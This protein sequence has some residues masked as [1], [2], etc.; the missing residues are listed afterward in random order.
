MRRGQATYRLAFQR[1]ETALRFATADFADRQQGLTVSGSNDLVAN[2]R[3]EVI[4]HIGID[5]VAEF[6]GKQLS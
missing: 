2:G 5:A 6:P 3:I 4:K 1:V